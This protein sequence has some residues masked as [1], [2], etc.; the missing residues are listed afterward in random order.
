MLLGEAQATDRAAGV[1]GE[2]D[3]GAVDAEAVPA[4]GFVEGGEALL[5]AIA[6]DVEH[7][8]LLLAGFLHG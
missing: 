4:G 7:A 8:L 1:F 6:V 2:V 5:A 3:G